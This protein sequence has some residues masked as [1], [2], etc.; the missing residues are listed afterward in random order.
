MLNMFD[1]EY[2]ENKF[3]YY[4]KHDVTLTYATGDGI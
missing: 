3:R 2:R 4:S 1:F